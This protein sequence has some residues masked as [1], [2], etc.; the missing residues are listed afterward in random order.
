MVLQGPV[1]AV[2]HS[3]TVP[4]P[5]PVAEIEP[6]GDGQ[7]LSVMVMTGVAGSGLTVMVTEALAVQPLA[8]VTVTV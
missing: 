8:F 5:Q 6:V 3:N 7:T 4:A 2:A 1:G